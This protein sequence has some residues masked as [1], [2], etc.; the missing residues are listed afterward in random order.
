M[1]PDLD[2]CFM[3]LS[4]K[5]VLN[6]K[7]EVYYI[8]ACMSLDVVAALVLLFKAFILPCGLASNGKQV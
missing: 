5:A 1:L 8:A 3:L 6:L 2:H 4:V 7:T